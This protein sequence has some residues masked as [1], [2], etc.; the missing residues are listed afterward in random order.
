MT[1]PQGI[2]TR[3]FVI[4]L[5]LFAGGAALVTALLMNIF[6]RKVEAATPFVRLVEVGEDDV[7]PEKWGV[8]WPQQYDGYK[9]TALATRTRFSWGRALVREDGHQSMARELL[10]TVRDDAE[11]RPDTENSERED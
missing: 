9:K 8:N 6:E 10:A 4:A 2:S 1:N 3:V 5:V 7:D 11:R